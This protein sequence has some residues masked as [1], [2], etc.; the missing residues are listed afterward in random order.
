QDARPLDEALLPGRPRQGPPR[1]RHE[2]PVRPGPGDARLRAQPARGESP[3]RGVLEPRQPHR[4]QLRRLRDE[5]GGSQSRAAARHGAG[6]RPEGGHGAV[7]VLRPW[8]EGEQGAGHDDVRRGRSRT[9]ACTA[10]HSAVFGPP[11]CLG[12]LPAWGSPPARGS[13]SRAAA[14]APPPPGG[15]V[16][17]ARAACRSAS[18]RRIARRR[19]RRPRPRARAALLARAPRGA[20]RCGAAGEEVL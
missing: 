3:L 16:G 20:G 14:A 12:A 9:R 19:R 1:I 2:E 11:P 17:L 18:A 10:P 5:A 4:C 6:L 13:P 7:E 8:W 15:A